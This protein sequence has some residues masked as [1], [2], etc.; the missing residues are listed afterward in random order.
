MAADFTVVG[1]DQEVLLCKLPP[2]AQ[3]E[4]ET[5]A[6]A[7]EDA[8]RNTLSDTGVVNLML[9]LTHLAPPAAH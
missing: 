8:R 4:I 2:R 9:D 7:Q 1:N 6:L 3:D 5:E